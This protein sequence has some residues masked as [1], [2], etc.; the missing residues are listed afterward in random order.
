MTL[1]QTPT[2]IITDPRGYLTAVH[3][4]VGIGKT[5]FGAQIPGHYFSLTEVGTAGVQVF[6]DPIFNWRG[7]IEKA[8]ELIAAKE[9]GFKE[10]REVTTIVVDTLENL[11]GYAGD[12]V[13][14]TQ[15]FVEKGVAH[16]FTKIDDVPYGK[17][18]KAAYTLLL[19]NLEALRLHGFGMLLLS[20]TKNR[21]VKWGGEEL[22]H[23]GFNLPPSVADAVEGAC[24]AIAQFVVE[25]EIVKTEEGVVTTIESGRYM[26]W[27]PTF[28]RVAKHRLEGFPEKL[29]LPMY[30]GWQ[31][32]VDAFRETVAAKKIRD[33][34]QKQGQ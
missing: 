16:K 33:Q 18:Y 10:Q 30:K 8:K 7:F 23:Q 1:A 29:P 28:L 32:Y 14:A 26:Y 34:K 17:G 31:V 27:Q 12:E 25:E 3:G 19:R 2:E 6:G 22:T 11:F 4:T 13:C 15:T 21:I 24:D 20:H 5:S 9:A